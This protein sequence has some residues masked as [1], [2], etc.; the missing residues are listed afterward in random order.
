[1]TEPTITCPNCRTD[2]PLTAWLAAPLIA[3]TRKQYEK[4]IADRD[5]NIADREAAILSQQAALDRDRAD[6][7]QQMAERVSVER[8]RI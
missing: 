1:M 6:I 5:R 2:I 4:V 7:D 8:S 3:A